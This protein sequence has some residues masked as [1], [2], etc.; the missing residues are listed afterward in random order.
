MNLPKKIIDS[1]VVPIAPQ[2]QDKAFSDSQISYIVFVSD[3]LTIK[4]RD[5]KI[6][7]FRN[8]RIAFRNINQRPDLLIDLNVQ[9]KQNKKT[10]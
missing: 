9:T 5:L 10:I 7:H 6:G 2:A 8:C 4:T 3:S 1:N